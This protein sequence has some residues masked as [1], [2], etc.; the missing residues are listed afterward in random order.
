MSSSEAEAFIKEIE[1]MLAA[2]AKSQAAAGRVESGPET[3]PGLRRRPLDDVRVF[4][5]TAEVLGSRP[6]IWRGLEIRS[7]IFLDD[8]HQILQAAFSWHDYQ[9][10]RFAIGAPVFQG[11]QE[12]LCGYDASEEDQGIPAD[13]VRLDE[14]MQSPGDTLYYAYDYDGDCWEIAVTLKDILEPVGEEYPEDAVCTAGERAAPPEGHRH[15]PRTLLNELLGDPDYFDPA[16]VNDRLIDD[17]PRAWLQKMESPVTDLLGEMLLHRVRMQI[18]RTAVGVA[19]HDPVR[20]EAEEKAAAL[21]AHQWFLDRAKDGGI[22]LTASGYLKP[23]VVSEASEIVPAAHIWIG[24]K[25]RED[26]TVPVLLFRRSMQKMGLLRRYRSKL[27]LTRKGIAARRSPEALWKHVAD[28]LVLG[29]EGEFTR[30]VAVLD[31]LAVAAADD[32]GRADFNLV[33][34]GLYAMGWST[35]DESPLREQDFSPH[36]DRP[37]VMLHNVTPGP[38]GLTRDRF[39][40]AAVAMAR[41]ALKLHMPPE[42]P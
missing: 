38:G 2:A 33:I 24:K 17:G 5:V 22:P 32:A 26:H 36:A 35:Q 9:L 25:N 27:L 6:L 40:R 7:N 3:R 13:E 10:H 30:D 14:T 31:L 39:S 42:R 23:E 16:E 34:E 41:D 12:F 18:L 29:K 15:A 21:A 20:L 19:R 8:L 4:R 28:G 11:G 37:R 1:Q